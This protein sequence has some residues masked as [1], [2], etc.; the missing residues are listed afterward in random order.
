MLYAMVVVSDLVAARVL[1]RAGRMGVG[2]SGA[3][4]PA[5]EPPIAM[6]CTQ[7]VTRSLEH[8]MAIA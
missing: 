3:V 2:W 1:S 7:P 5:D 8:G 4:T 6:V